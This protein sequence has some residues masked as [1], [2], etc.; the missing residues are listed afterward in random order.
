MHIRVCASRKSEID[1]YSDRNSS[2]ESKKSELAIHTLL[3]DTR[4]G[5]L[6]REVYQ[7]PDSDRCLFRVRKSS[8]TRQMAWR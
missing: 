3:V 7:N 1:T 5:Y 2:S 4:A 8:I 6:D